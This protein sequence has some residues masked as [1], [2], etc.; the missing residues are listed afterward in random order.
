MRHEGRCVCSLTFHIKQRY[1]NLSVY[2]SPES[3][4]SNTHISIRHQE[5]ISN[6]LVHKINLSIMSLIFTQLRHRERWGF[7]IY[8]ADYTSEFNWTKFTTILNTWTAW[9]IEDY[10]PHEAPLLHSWQ[11]MWWFDDKRQFEKAHIR[12]L[13]NHFKGTW[14][15][16]LTAE[17]GGRVWP[18]HY[19]FLMVDNEVLASVRPHST[20]ISAHTGEFPFVKCWDGKAPVQG[21]DYP[22]YMK[23]RIPSIFSLYG[24]ALDAEVQSMRAVCPRTTEWFSRHKVWVEDDNWLEEEGEEDGCE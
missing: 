6:P 9:V 22:G 17:E 16:G 5:L 13:R 18:E 14:Y 2:I 23:V 21:E 7:V 24:A 10:G 8:R 1:T 4:K 12:F 20:D 3:Q 15:T 19:M 11:K